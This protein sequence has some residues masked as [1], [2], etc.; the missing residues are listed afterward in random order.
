MV[1]ELLGVC[2]ISLSHGGQSKMAKDASD[3]SR[4]SR[5]RILIISSLLEAEFLS[6]CEVFQHWLQVQLGVECDVV[7]G[8]RQMSSWKPYAYYLVVLLFR[9]IFRDQQFTKLLLY[10]SANCPISHRSLEIVPVIADGNFDFPSMDSLLKNPIDSPR[11]GAQAQ[12]QVH[13]R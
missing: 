3:A 4:S 9:G 10:A 13:R 6:A 8:V 11:L 5:P 7:H 1:V 2:G 12:E